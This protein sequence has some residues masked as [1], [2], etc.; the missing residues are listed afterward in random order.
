[1][2][3]IYDYVVRLSH[4]LYFFLRSVEAKAEKKMRVMNNDF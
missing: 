4:I 2:P 1:M 3:Q